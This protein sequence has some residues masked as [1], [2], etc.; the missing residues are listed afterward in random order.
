MAW[1]H[2]EKEE[3]S[4]RSSAGNCWCWAAADRDK[5]RDCLW[6]QVDYWFERVH[7]SSQTVAA[8]AIEEDLVKMSER[9][10]RTNN[11]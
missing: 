1:G 10:K 8:L 2:F 3:R 9:D 5:K 4:S 7:S 11:P 6:L